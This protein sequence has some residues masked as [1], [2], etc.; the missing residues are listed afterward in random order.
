M[1]G[2]QLASAVN[3][4]LLV[5]GAFAL[6]ACSPEPSST[7]EVIAEDVTP[8]QGCTSLGDR[9]TLSTSRG[10][11]AVGVSG[12][13]IPGFSCSGWLRLRFDDGWVFVCSRAPGPVVLADNVVIRM[14]DD[15][16]TGTVSLAFLENPP[17][18]DVLLV[19]DFQNLDEGW[20]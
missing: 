3:A 20:W 12:P 16:Q 13:R 9:I 19:V 5:A 8:D 15:L 11:S 17:C 4:S 2:N 18:D 10:S 14:D 7:F 1:P 6:N